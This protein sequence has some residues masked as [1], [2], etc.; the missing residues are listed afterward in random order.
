[1]NDEL[2][3]AALRE[4]RPAALPTDL[5]ARMQAQPPPGPVTLPWW[6]DV[7]V[8]GASLLAAAAT[9]VWMVVPPSASHPVDPLPRSVRIHQTESTLLAERTLA[10]EE[11]DGRIWELVE[12]EWRD[13]SIALCSDSPVRVRYSETRVER[14]CQP[15]DFQ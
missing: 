12:Q 9:I 8:I 10:V 1:M 5:K 3:E 2:L 15:V 13:D 6:R 11:H 14:L 7:R 4:L